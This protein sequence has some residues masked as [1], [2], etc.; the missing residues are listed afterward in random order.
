MVGGHVHSRQG[1]ATRPDWGISTR[2]VG[3][4]YGRGRCTKIMFLLQRSDPQDTGWP[5]EAIVGF[6]LSQASRTESACAE[7]GPG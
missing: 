2:Q 4:R 7:M 1:P 5:G 6:L 3:S